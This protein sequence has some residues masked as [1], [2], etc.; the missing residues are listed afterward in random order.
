MSEEIRVKV[1]KSGRRKYLIMYY[2]DP[3]TRKREQRSTR[4]TTR[5][6]AERVA[7]KWEAELQEGRYKP[8]SK[9][10]WAEFR[11]AFDEQYLRNWSAA[12]QRTFSSVFAQVESILTPQRLC[13][14]TE[15][16]LVYLVTKI[17]DENIGLEEAPKFRSRSTVNTYVRH[18]QV[19]LNWATKT[20]KAF[21]NVPDVTMPAME[22]DD[23]MKG[24]PISGEEFDRMI[25]AIRYGLVG[26]TSSDDSKTAK[27]KR[28]QAAA[29]A[30]EIVA[31]LDRLLRGYWLSGLRLGEG[32][33]LSWDEPHKIAIDLSGRR[34]KLIF[35]AHL[36]KRRKYIES[37]MTPDFAEFLLE[38]PADRRNGAVFQPLGLRGRGTRDKDW[39]S[40]L[41]CR[42]GEAAGVIVKVDQQGRAKKYASTHDLRRSFGD[43]WSR[44][45][46]PPVLKDLMRH[47]S[48]ETTM[49]YYRSRNADDTADSLWDWHDSQ[50][51][52]TFVGSRGKSGIQQA[53]SSP[54]KK[55]QTI[56]GSRLS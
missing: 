22:E 48:I 2:D 6:K 56:E 34:P 20:L 29:I 54:T 9:I 15:P 24:R 27:R 17:R 14:L 28:E 37:P 18:L 8:P 47:R 30:T 16:R 1:T 40:S 21:P 11:D 55:P 35:P 51:V 25:Q 42:I 33:N 3:I 31:S 52:G 43:R 45:V 5:T 38:T 23:E 26:L 46:M 4:E 32:L 13:D 7:A 12:Y 50:D 10:T 39:V 36:N 49:K 19:A 53:D 41:I 44:R